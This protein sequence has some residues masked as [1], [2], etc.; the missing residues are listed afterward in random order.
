MIFF[1]HRF[2]PSEH[3]YHVQNID[4]INNTPS[5]STIIT[6]FNEDNLDIIKYAVANEVKLALHVESVKDIVYANALGASYLVVGK[7]MAKTAQN[8]ADNYLFDAKILVTIEDENEI[9][10]FALL[11]IDGIVCSNA[12]IKIN[13]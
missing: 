1:G 7:T 11:G 8:L 2:I 9:E 6:N 3:F 5:N 13:S 4:A 12:I 10:E